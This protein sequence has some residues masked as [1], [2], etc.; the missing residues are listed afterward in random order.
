MK[1]T[2]IQININYNLIYN[3]IISH[4][5][6]KIKQLINKNNKILYS[7]P[8]QYYTNSIEQFFSKLKSG[9]QKK[10]GLKYE[11][12]KR[13]IIE[14]IKDIPIIFYYKILKSSYDIKNYTVKRNYIKKYIRHILNKNKIYF[15]KNSRLNC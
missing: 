6:E 15:Y 7:I 5:N 4:R 8:Y 10:K 11:E 14:V 13:N 1:N 3:K 12:L 2:I 9:L